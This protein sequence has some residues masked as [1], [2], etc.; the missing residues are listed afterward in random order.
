M[1][2]R[3]AIINYGMGNLRS[4]ENALL[5]VGTSPKIVT[6]PSEV[7]DVEGLVLPG[8]GALED[9][10]D[11][12]RASKF[13]DFIGGWIQDDRPF[14]GVCLGLQALFDVS[15]ERN[16]KGLGIFPGKVAR[17]VSKPGLKIPHMGWNRAKLEQKDSPFWENLDSEEDRFYFVHSYYAKPENPDLV[18]TTTDYDG[19]FTSSIG[20]SNTLACQFHPEKSQAKGL[21]IYSN[22]ASICD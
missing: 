1:S 9:C 22:F 19:V 7:S 17:F 14:M 3:I 6:K 20:R 15:E 16:V 10:V 12:L 11:G 2:A 13:D 18:L 8:V 4:V 5:K 21:Q